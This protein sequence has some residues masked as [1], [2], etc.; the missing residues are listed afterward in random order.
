[1]TA[2]K[3]QTGVLIHR[4]GF[5]GGGLACFT[6][7]P[8]PLHISETKVNQH[9][10]QPHRGLVYTQPLLGVHTPTCLS[11]LLQALPG[12]QELTSATVEHCPS[13]SADAEMPPFV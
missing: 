12:S 13:A 9:Q 10:A 5:T 2:P 11:C 6:A 1:M 8:A 7:T 3:T 4:T